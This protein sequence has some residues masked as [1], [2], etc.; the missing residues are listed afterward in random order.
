LEAVVA[1]CAVNESGDQPG[2]D[3]N[4]DDRKAEIRQ[5]IVQVADNAPK[6][7]IEP[8]WFPISPS[9]S[10]PPMKMAT[11]TD[12]AVMARLYQSLRAFGDRRNAPLAPHP[13]HSQEGR[14]L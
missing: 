3:E 8:S 9:A 6:A 1:P 7:G 5:V 12:A 10:T 4:T 14:G 2:R 11:K 13:T